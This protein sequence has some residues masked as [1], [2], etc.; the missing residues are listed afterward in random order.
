[1][2]KAQYTKRNHMLSIIDTNV[3][4]T[5]TVS[6]KTGC[7]DIIFADDETAIAVRDAITA[8]HPFEPKEPPASAVES[9]YKARMRGKLAI[10][11]GEFVSI[12]GVYGTLEQANHRMRELDKKGF[13]TVQ[14][15]ECAVDE[16]CWSYVGGYEE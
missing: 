10:Q 6:A 9:D 12:M 1:M 2:I 5:P 7:V 11:C 16:D 3:S 15:R 13:D 14:V 4:R 8:E